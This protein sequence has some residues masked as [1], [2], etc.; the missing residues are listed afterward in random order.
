MSCAVL[1][2]AA[3]ALQA[4][5]RIHGA[6]TDEPAALLSAGPRKIV[7]LEAS[8]AARAAGVEP[9]STPPQALARCP[10]LR[11]HTRS[12]SAE[13]EAEAVLFAA[14]WSLSPRLE[15][16][17]AGVCTIDRCGAAPEDFLRR[18][19]GVLE[20]LRAHGLA[21]TLGV[22][23]TPLLS[24]Y[25]ARQADP[26]LAV[27]DEPAFLFPLPLALAAPPAPLASLLE[28]WGIRTCGA[29]TALA[30]AEVGR[31]LG[32]EGVALWE[33]AGGETD[34]P[35]APLA[36]PA[37][38]GA[39]LALASEVE[40][41]E[42]LLF[43]L[44]RLVDRLALQLENARLVAASL[45]LALELADETEHARDFRL[46]E[47]TASPEI[48]F[49][50]LH[51]HLEGLRTAAPIRGLRLTAAPMRLPTR[52]PGLFET[53]LR[54]PHGFTETLARL[55]A[56]LG[57]DRVGT[58]QPEPSRRP[59]AFRLDS[60]GPVVPPP[61][62]PAVLPPLG[63]ALRRFRPPDAARVLTRGAVP[64][65]LTCRAADGLIVR[66]GGPWQSS[67]EWWKPEGWAC[68]EWDVELAGGGLY[69]L[70]RDGDRWCV[71]GMYD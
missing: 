39:A 32:A 52:Q 71:E 49:R 17:A 60:P 7:L 57:P 38:F 8:A 40:T 23:R 67:G 35:L 64:V 41:L 65:Q 13:R 44:R 20:R 9:G 19:R 69:R 61:P 12:P 2:L 1:H 66:T 62:P 50:A 37:E 25:A 4:V 15:R 26:A 46:P 31:R 22:A 30:K 43:V 53:G 36:P 33:R 27:T 14:A 47:P 24:L 45:A 59:D 10:G 11:L 28:Q 6:D 51:T 18:G 29:L 54:D 58:P 70:A 55:A 56:L 16:T 5:R 21:A 42:P 63:L 3:F 34:R 68:E 48:I